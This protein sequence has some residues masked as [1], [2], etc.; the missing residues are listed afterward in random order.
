MIGRVALLGF[1]QFG[2]HRRDIG[3]IAGLGDQIR[4][5]LT[6]LQREDGFLFL[7]RQDLLLQGIELPLVVLDRGLIAQL[8][9]GHRLA[10]LALHF[11]N[12]EIDLAHLL[13]DPLGLLLQKSGRLAR[14]LRAHA[15]G[16]R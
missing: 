7:S 16:C 9:L 10:V 15:A 4:I 2:P 13:R 8:Q 14:G 6:E 3:E 12:P 11:R 1:R 5:H